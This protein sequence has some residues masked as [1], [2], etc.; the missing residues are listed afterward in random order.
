MKIKFVLSLA[1]VS[2]CATT[3]SAFLGSRDKMDLKIFVGNYNLVSSGSGDICANEIT[4]I[5]A[6]E[7][8]KLQTKS[9][10]KARDVHALCKVDQGGQRKVAKGGGGHAI[11]PSLDFTKVTVTSNAAEKK[12]TKV[13]SETSVSIG[14]FDWTSE[15]TVQMENEN[16]MTV[17]VDLKRSDLE[18]SLCVYMRK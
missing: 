16:Q 10:G 7:G 2:L 6:C 1:L 3:A 9:N 15:T 5:E 8:L 17:K 13:E 18:P 12:L 14:I 4:V 11:F